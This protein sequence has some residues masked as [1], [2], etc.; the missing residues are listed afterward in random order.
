M[1]ECFEFSLHA[2]FQIGEVVDGPD[3]VA[4]RPIH[5]GVQYDFG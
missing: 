1:V 5:E 2:F 3:G 4:D